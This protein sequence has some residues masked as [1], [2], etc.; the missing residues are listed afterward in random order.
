MRLWHFSTTKRQWARAFL[1][2]IAV[3]AVSAAIGVLFG[4]PL[5]NVIVV[6]WM[7]TLWFV[8]RTRASLTP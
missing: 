2:A 1:L 3:A 6:A 4:G 5:D 8:A 7:L